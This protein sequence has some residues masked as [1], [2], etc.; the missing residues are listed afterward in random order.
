MEKPNLNA[1][2]RLSIMGGVFY[3]CEHSLLHKNYRVGELSE[4]VLPALQL[5][6]FRYYDAPGGEPIA[7]VCW[8]FATDETV[9]RLSVG[10]PLDGIQD[11]TSGDTLVFVDFLAPF[12]FL[13]Q[14]RADLTNNVFASGTVG[15]GFRP[16]YDDAG[17][18]TKV[19]RT[20]YR[21]NRRNDTQFGN[22]GNLKEP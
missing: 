19:R 14:I 4:N 10:E 9:R 6:Q 12:G 2:D 5:G 13:D 15:I 22:T 21:F 1:P 11:W 16:S 18:L 17:N 8:A 3:L 20:I 7:F